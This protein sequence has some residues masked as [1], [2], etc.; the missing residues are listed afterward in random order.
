MAPRYPDNRGKFAGVGQWS[1]APGA[2]R[3]DNPVRTTEPVTTI[4]SRGSA[5]RGAF[6]VSTTEDTEL[7]RAQAEA[8]EIKKRQDE[9]LARHGSFPVQPANS[10]SPDN[11]LSDAGGET[12]S[13]PAPASVPSESANSDGTFRSTVGSSVSAILGTP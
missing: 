10:S 5:P 8:E 9:Y 2:P 13:L 3:G 6:R 1:V 12:P 4:A 11:R 7:L